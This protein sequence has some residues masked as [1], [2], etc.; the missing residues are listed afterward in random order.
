VRIE[1]EPFQPSLSPASVVT[2]GKFDG[3]H[4]G[5]RAVL[6]ETV[7]RA[8]ALDVEAVVVTFDRNPLALLRPD[9]CPPA[10]V[11]LDR[12]LELLAATEIDLVVVLTFDE[13]R[14]SEAPVAFVDEL[15]VSRLGARSVLVGRD[16][17]F[18]AKGQ[19]DVWQLRQ[20]GADRGFTVD[21]LPDVGG[22]GADRISTSGIRTLVIEGRVAEAAARLGSLP[23]VTGEVV[24][25][26][27]RGRDLGFPTA[28]LTTEPGG[29]VPS[30]GVYAGWLTARGERMPAAISVSDNPTFDTADQ[31]RVEAYV[32]DRDVDLYG[33]TVTVEFEERIRGIVTFDSI[34]ALIERMTVDV[35]EA[36]SVLQR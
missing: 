31:R 10:L 34:E 18:G 16:F 6:A 30:D 5:H 32:I 23:A 14:A 26:N 33:E 7:R 4:L 9:I 27:A 2:I 1:R 25:G 8:R 29:V 17:R 35:A 15:L 20:Y 36:R 21:M 19:G 11:S 22:F 28:N 13:M 24:H 3:V 12:K